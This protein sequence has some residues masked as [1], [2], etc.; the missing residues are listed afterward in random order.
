MTLLLAL[1][2]QDKVSA[3]NGFE[4]RDEKPGPDRLATMVSTAVG[5]HGSTARGTEVPRKVLI[6]ELEKMSDLKST[7]SLKS[8]RVFWNDVELEL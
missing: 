7:Q 1:L 3:W 8:R 4:R 5:K 2:L 6:E